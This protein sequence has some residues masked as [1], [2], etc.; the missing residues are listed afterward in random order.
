MF[1]QFYRERPLSPFKGTP[2]WKIPLS[3]SFYYHQWIHLPCIK[4]QELE[5]NLK[6]KGKNWRRAPF[7][8]NRICFND[9]MVYLIDLVHVYGQVGSSVCVQCGVLMR[10][11]ANLLTS[12]NQR[13]KP[14]SVVVKYNIEFLLVVY[15]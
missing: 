1:S 12:Y 8:F 13:I 4:N 14:N 5:R 3:K 7:S 6:L 10:L 9:I 15:L 2:I 11:K